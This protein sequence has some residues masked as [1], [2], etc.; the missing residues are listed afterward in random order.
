MDI[1]Y[2]LLAIYV[3]YTNRFSLWVFERA[4]II[5]IILSLYRYIGEF[6]GLPVHRGFSTANIKKR[7]ELH[8]YQKSKGRAGKAREWIENFFL[9]YIDTPKYYFMYDI[10]FLIVILN[11]FMWHHLLIWWIYNKWYYIKV[12]F[13]GN[14]DIFFKKY[15]KIDSTKWFIIFPKYINGFITYL[16]LFPL[17]RMVFYPSYL[18]EQ[19]LKKEW[20]EFFK[21]R[22]FGVVYSLVY[23]GYGVYDPIYNLPMIWKIYLVYFFFAVIMP[24]YAT[25]FSKYISSE[26]VILM[27][28]LPNIFYQS[29]I[30]HSSLIF[31]FLKEYTEV[32]NIY[33]DNYILRRYG[34]FIHMPHFFWVK[35]DIIYEIGNNYKNFWAYEKCYTISPILYYFRFRNLWLNYISIEAYYIEGIK[36]YGKK[37]MDR[38]YLKFLKREREYIKCLFFILTDCRRKLGFPVDRSFLPDSE[39]PVLL[40]KSESEIFAYW[41]YHIMYWIDYRFIPNKFESIEEY[42]KFFELMKFIDDYGYF[43]SVLD[44]MVERIKKDAI[45]MEMP[46]YCLQKEEREQLDNQNRIFINGIYKEYF[47]DYYVRISHPREM[48]SEKAIKEFEEKWGKKYMFNPNVLYDNEKEDP[49]DYKTYL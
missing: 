47:D 14:K 46:L 37:Y 33:L 19:I 49:Y 2:I 23:I 3:V 9:Y 24:I 16:L 22:V 10:V 8:F 42:K 12:W 6:F 18:R 44:D 36:L 28:P 41:Y 48:V 11:P 1:I 13:N 34:F 21:I 20:Y 25:F 26:Y 31:A 4:I 29:I 35:V 27:Y 32:L 45:I 5:L 7:P 15:L 30:A 17:L 39:D 38:K 43:N 40:K